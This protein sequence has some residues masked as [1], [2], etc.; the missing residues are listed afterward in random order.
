VRR[1]ALSE[2]YQL[3]SIRPDGVDDPSSF[4]WYLERPLTA[5]QLARSVQLMLRG[6]YKNDDPIVGSFRQQFLDVL[7]DENIVTISDALFLTNN[8]QLDAFLNAS[9]EP[10]HLLKQLSGLE[11][12]P[13]RASVLFETIL[14]R[15]P[16][17]DEVAAIAAYLDK[18]HDSLEPALQQVVWSLLTSAEFRF[19]H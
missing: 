7:P 10:E 1:I 6:S 17:A 11:S 16:D 15:S 12:Q 5:E 9:W 19:N 8:P 18:R 4:A 3:S 2:A 13:E 14:C